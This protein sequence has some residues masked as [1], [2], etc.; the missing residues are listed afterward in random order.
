MIK[1]QLAIPYLHF[2]RKKDKKGDKTRKKKDKKK[3]KKGDREAGRMALVQSVDDKYR[4]TIDS[5]KSCLRTSI[6]IQDHRGVQTRNRK[7]DGKGNR[8]SSPLPSSPDAGFKK[9]KR[10]TFQDY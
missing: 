4:N 10:V 9:T 7:R 5:L 1:S 6:P 3:T 2:R 8:S